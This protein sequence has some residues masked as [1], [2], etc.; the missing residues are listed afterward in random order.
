MDLRHLPAVR[1]QHKL[2][3]PLKMTKFIAIFGDGVLF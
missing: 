3:E 1:C 2:E